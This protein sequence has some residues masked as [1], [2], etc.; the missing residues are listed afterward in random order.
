LASSN[1]AIRAGKNGVVLKVRLSPKSSRDEIAGVEDYAGEMV[2]KARVRAVPEGGRANAALTTLIARWLGL[3]PTSV[4][5]VRGGKSRLKE[6]AIDGDDATLAQL[7]ADRL[8][9]LT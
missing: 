2:L 8:G 3:P 6:I 1:L 4:S 7:I 5:I 9:E